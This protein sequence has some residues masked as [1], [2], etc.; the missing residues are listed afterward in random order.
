MRVLEL[1][2]V[3]TIQYPLPSCSDVCRDADWGAHRIECLPVQTSE[4]PDV[5][6]FIG[7]FTVQWADDGDAAAWRPAAPGSVGAGSSWETSTGGCAARP[8]PRRRRLPCSAP[9]G[10]GATAAVQR[11]PAS[12]GGDDDGNE[13]EGEGEGPQWPPAAEQW[14]PAD[15]AGGP[16][17]TSFRLRRKVFD[18]GELA[19]RGCARA[20]PAGWRRR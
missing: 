2:S 17:P 4:A 10:S 13:G 15:A 9:R 7:I 8:L 19:A 12:A 6:M 20:R 5:C 1:K 16:L 18:L 11:S 14:P 3:A